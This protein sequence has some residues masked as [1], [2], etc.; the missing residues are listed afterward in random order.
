MTALLIEIPV[1]FSLSL[2]LYQPFMYSSPKLSQFSSCLCPLSRDFR[3]F[4]L[5]IC[6]FLSYL[7]RNLLLFP[8]S[9]S[10]P[11]TL[12]VPLFLSVPR[13]SLVHAFCVFDQFVSR[14]A[15]QGEAELLIKKSRW[16]GGEVTEGGERQIQR[17]LQTWGLRGGEYVWRFG[18]C[19]HLYKWY[20]IVCMWWPYQNKL[21]KLYHLIHI[22]GQVCVY[23]RKTLH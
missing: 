10:G 7:Y 13:S 5:W 15:L 1:Y 16:K 9:L 2:S 22:I 18:D 21:S 11:F 19:Y 17:Q 12:L 20:V 14:P 4:P 8:L 6:P 3:D 23:T